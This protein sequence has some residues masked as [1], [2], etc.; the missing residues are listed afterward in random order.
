MAEGELWSKDWEDAQKEIQKTLDENPGMR[1]MDKFLIKVK[2]FMNTLSVEE[3][4][5]VAEEISKLL[6]YK[7]REKFAEERRKEKEHDQQIQESDISEE[8]QGEFESQSLL[9]FPSLNKKKRK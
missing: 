1:S 2:G 7:I 4:T 9:C 3:K 8:S 5:E 6:N